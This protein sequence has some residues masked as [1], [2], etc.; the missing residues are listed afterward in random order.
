VHRSAAGTAWRWRT[1]LI[2]FGGLLAALAWLSGQIT[3]RWASV[4]L[5]AALGMLFLTPGHMSVNVACQNRAETG[6]IER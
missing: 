4:V 6:D 1:E 3:I 5:A 2:V